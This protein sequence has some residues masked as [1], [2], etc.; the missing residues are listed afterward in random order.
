MNLA[1][2][3][4]LP[5]YLGGGDALNPGAGVELGTREANATLVQ[6]EG[7]DALSKAF[8]AE[9]TS[10]KK[11]I[12]ATTDA[13]ERAALRKQN[14]AKAFWPRFEALS[15]S[16]EGQALLWMAGHAKDAGVERAQIPATKLR[17]YKALVKDHTGA[18]WFDDVLV[19]LSAEKKRNLS[20]QE[21]EGLLSM[22]GANELAS[23]ETRA[24]AT[25]VLARLLI[26]ADDKET[27]ARGKQLLNSIPDK[28]PGTS[29]A[30]ATGL[31]PGD[32]APDFKGKTIDGHE[33]K[34]SDYRGKVV[35]VDFYGFW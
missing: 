35:L 8:D 33:F 24:H 6:N 21:R 7:F 34:L 13:K 23:M 5:L 15:K 30:T 17:L 1:I 2:L 22:V 3:M 27:Q 10:W 4:T 29:W 16:G 25:V 18:A 11:T 26:D 12:K 20:L 28:F 9:V 14:P 32:L 19:G 31:S